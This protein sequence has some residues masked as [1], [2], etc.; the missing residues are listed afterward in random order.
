MNRDDQI[1][2]N[3]YYLVLGEDWKRPYVYGAVV[4]YP[5]G[6]FVLMPALDKTGYGWDTIVKGEIIAE[7]TGDEA[8]QM[9]PRTAEGMKSLI[10]SITEEEYN[11]ANFYMT[12]GQMRK[13]MNS[14]M[15]ANEG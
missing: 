10:C 15:K 1:K 13:R 6:T 9:M 8:Y 11:N 12:K 2:K 4:A 14:E 3:R 7:I 5:E